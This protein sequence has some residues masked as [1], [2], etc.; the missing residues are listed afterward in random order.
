M[1][2][3]KNN[4]FILPGNIRDRFNYVLRQF[5]NK[6]PMIFLLLL[7][8]ISLFLIGSFAG[9][10]LGGF[11]GTIDNPSEKG[12]VFLRSIGLQSGSKTILLGIIHENIKIPYN[13]IQGQFSS[14]E[15]IYIDIK[16]KDYEK[17][18]Y[19]RDQ[20]LGDIAIF[21]SDED[22]VPATIRYKDKELKAKVRLKGDTSENLEGDKW[23]MR[24][25]LKDSG[26]L[27]G[28]HSF[29]IQHPKIRNYLNEL[30]YHESL[31]KEG[32]IGLRYDFV[33]V[34][35]NG[36]NRG[37]YS[38]EEHFDTELIE[39][40][41]KR[42]GI[43]I[44]VNE[45]NWYK[46]LAQYQEKNLE[47]RGFINEELNNEFSLGD[48][49]I[50]L[51]QDYMVNYLYGAD[52]G[53]FEGNIDAFNSNKV[54]LDPVLNEQFTI[55]RN[56]LESFRRGELKTSEVFDSE[57]LAKYF[58]LA[59]I[60]GAEHGADWTN[61]RF[62]Y[63][64][65]TSKLEPIGFNG[66]AG[67]DN[68]KIIHKFF[69]RCIS[70]EEVDC[71][72]INKNY[73]NILFSDPVFF[74]KFISE[75]ER[76]SDQK[77]IDNLIS[78]LEQILD[79]KRKI[80]YK[81]M[82]YYY[83]SKEI[84]YENQEYIRKILNQNKDSIQAHYKGLSENKKKI[85]LELANMNHLPIKIIS[86]NYGEVYLDKLDNNIMLQPRKYSGP[87]EFTEYY[88]EIPEG[89]NENIV[90]SEPILNYKVFGSSVL[91]NQSVSPWPY[92]NDSA[93]NGEIFLKN[94]SLNPE[95]FLR[96]DEPNKKIYFKEGNWVLNKSIIIPEGYNL[97]IGKNTK[98]DL[99]E[100]AFIL[101]YSEVYLIG[102]KLNPTFITSSDKKGQ[103]LAVLNAK[104]GSLLENVVFENLTYPSKNGWSLTG[105]VT[106]YESPVI[107]NSAQFSNIQA[108]DN[109][110]II[111][112]SFEIHNIILTDSFSDCI[113]ID[114]SEG[115]IDNVICN[116]CSNDCIDFSGSKALISNIF[117]EN[118][119]DKALSVGEKSEIKAYNVTV[120][121][122][123]IGVA[124]KDQSSLEL[125]NII[126]DNSNYG[127]VAYQK[128]S[129]FGPA[130]IKAINSNVVADKIHFIEK[131]SEL[132][133]EG[134]II[135]GSEKQVYD[136]LYPGG[137][138]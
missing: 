38:I 120:K 35:V 3:K 97:N 101:S 124:S 104:K 10:I 64:P 41:N 42:D 102:D 91:K 49:I 19:K 95:E 90:L 103:G 88:F 56:L 138:K 136:L 30:I 61:I 132:V 100:G 133:L 73:Y 69:P 118:L 94:P 6:K 18:L 113:D 55:A 57:I 66:Y 17:L 77:Y 106:F 62:Y 111:R 81:D 59:S 128:K 116:K 127:F 84:F 9:L 48:E 27:F 72:Y 78:D 20:V 87:L 99:R 68:Y 21:Y 22:F 47:G 76:M 123:N 114:F 7:I 122:S 121:N 92:K 33:Q 79:E 43:I 107:I 115:A 26:S 83:F 4:S 82:P 63:N 32:V 39:N 109:L 51:D 93:L 29:S 60:L 117:A 45:E 131:K 34:I 52:K 24:I 5:L 54:L 96:I 71:S 74:E 75:L 40:N 125:D 105:A 119:G 12:R 126:I 28:M 13:F 89:L 110:N 112:S 58:A 67:I 50:S 37:I 130:V 44:K 86:L 25:N 11:F 85:V 65:I 53:F 134:K 80:I 8:M 137:V 70:I 16:F 129:E 36:D 15:K 98:I 14:P 23:S 1:R 135:I 108:E 31:K 2:L 46:D